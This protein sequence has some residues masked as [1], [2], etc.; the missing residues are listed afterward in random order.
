MLNHAYGWRP[1]LP[2]QRDKRLSL[3]PASYPPYVDL[4]S[5]LPAVYDQGQLGS[6]TAN[7]LAGAMQFD[8]WKEKIPGFMP[9]RL[10]LY[11]N[12]RVLEGT[13]DS[14]AGASLRDGLKTMVSDGVCPESAWPYEISQFAVDPPNAIYGWA[15]AYKTTSYWSLSQD[16]LNLRACLTARYPFVFGFSVYESFESPAVAQTGIVPMPQPQE[17]LLGGHAVLCVGYNE[18]RQCFWCRNSWGASW[19]IDGHFWMPYEYLLSADLASD[20]W[21][22]RKVA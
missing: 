4:R 22:I 13:V 9:S 12:E 14:D 2:D 21:T 20:F 18:A 3:V 10:F 19:G 11:Y 16:L 5:A 7:A 1:D 6:C 8:Q 15:A 17:A